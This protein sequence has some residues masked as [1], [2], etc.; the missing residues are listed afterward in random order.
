MKRTRNNGT[1]S[2]REEIVRAAA[3]TFAAKGYLATTLDEIA[4]EIGVSKPALYYHI[5]NK[6]EILRE[7]IGRIME[8]MEEVARVGK[9]DLGPKERVEL[10]IRMLVKFAVERKEITLIALEQSR[11]LP[12]RSQDALRRRQKEV[13]KVLQETLREGKQQG[14]FQVEDVKMASFAILAVS[15][16]IYRWYQPGGTMTAKVISDQ[17]IELLENGFVKK[18]A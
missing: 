2:R 1:V 9:S 17:F 11:I 8:P 10:M 13:E 3:K 4:K 14:I 15:N 5:K 12:K 18:K 6:E 16:W 7:I